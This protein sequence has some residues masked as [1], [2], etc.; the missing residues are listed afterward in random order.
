MRHA[1]RYEIHDL[2]DHKAA[3]LTKKGKNDSYLLGRQL[4]RNNK[5]A[6]IY[7]SPVPRCKQ[8]AEYISQSMIDSKAKG[9]IGRALSWLEGNYF[10]MDRTYVNNHIQNNST[11]AFLRSW[12]DNNLPREIITP[13]EEIASIQYRFIKEL[14]RYH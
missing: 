8:T 5:Q 13:V 10:I 3:M 1:E 7:Y 12:F 2:R 14:L 4:A 11:Q 6:K 9:M